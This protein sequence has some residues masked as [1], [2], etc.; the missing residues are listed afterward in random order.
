MCGIAGIFSRHGQVDRDE[1]DRFTDALAHRGPDGR[2]I[3]VNGPLG[4]GH[5]RLAIL[6]LTDAGKCP[7]YYQ[8]ADGREFW[9]TY[10][11]EVYNFLELRR[12]LEARGYRFCSDADTEVIVAAFAEWGSDAQLRFNGMW[13]FAIW[14]VEKRELFLSRDRFGIKPLHFSTEGGRFAF[15][16]EIKAFLALNNFTPHLDNESVNLFLSNPNAYDGISIST[17]LSSIKRLPAGHSLRVDSSGSL[18]C[19]KWWDTSEH[20]PAIPANESEQIERFRELFLDAVKIRMRSDVPVGTCLS[21]GVDSGAV[22]STMAW[23]HQTDSL[24]ERCPA[25]WQRTFVATFPGTVVDERYYAE[26]IVRHT[27]AKPHFWEFDAVAAASCIPDSIW[28]LD[29]LSNAPSVPVWNIYR[30]MRKEGVFVSLDG[31]GGDELLG[32]YTFYLDL[33]LGELNQALFHDFHATIMPAILRNYDRCSMSHGIEVRMPIM[34]WR[35]VTYSFA[36]DAEMKIGRGF[37]KRILRESMKGIMPD[38]VRL[39]RSKIGFASPLIEW[40]NQGIPPIIKEILNCRFW[41]ESPYWNGMELR[42]SI[43]QRSKLGAWTAADNDFLRQIWMFM[44][45]VIW[46]SLYI[47]QDNTFQLQTIAGANNG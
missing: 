19:E 37:T 24:L 3:Y 45:F 29:D 44:S 21:G 31:H 1:L 47:E 6:D 39:R 46:H 12:D 22:A 5:R 13:A 42:R 17:G 27:K 43:F 4:L 18:Q 16:S 30:E 10:N 32:G 8:A 20:I 2:G 41:L 15:A 36:L 14:D 9:I 28:A 25:D 38:L 40:F 7:M 23:L 33:P 35:L 26:K 34:D 11:G